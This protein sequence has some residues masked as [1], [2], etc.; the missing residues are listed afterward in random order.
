[1]PVEF[2]MLLTVPV[3]DPDQEDHNWKR[4][5]NCLHLITSPLVCILTLKSGACK[6]LAC[7]QQDPHG[8]ALVPWV[9]IPR[10]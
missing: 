9:G 4:P 6:N 2:V 7:S 1:M 10:L 5:L 3:V 8:R